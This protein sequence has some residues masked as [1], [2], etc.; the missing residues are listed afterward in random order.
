MRFQAEA[1]HL[2]SS[3]LIKLW[4]SLRPLENEG[5]L[6]RTIKNPP[7][8][9]IRERFLCV[10][11]GFILLIFL[12]I[13]VLSNEVLNNTQSQHKWFE[14]LAIGIQKISLELINAEAR[15]KTQ[16]F[17]IVEGRLLDSGEIGFFGRRLFTEIAVLNVKHLDLQL[18]ELISA[19]FANASANISIAYVLIDVLLEL[20]V[21]LN[22]YKN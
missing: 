22:I 1:V 8:R 2:F 18:N 12:P 17:R 3:T 11:K 4:N 19:V 6:R 14:C 9:V 5:F 10:I 21:W 15:C 16:N 13:L 7:T 20:T